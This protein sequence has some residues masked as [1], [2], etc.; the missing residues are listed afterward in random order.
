VPQPIKITIGPENT[1][2]SLRLTTIQ[3]DVGAFD[4]LEQV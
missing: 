4:W 3:G 2:G 1:V